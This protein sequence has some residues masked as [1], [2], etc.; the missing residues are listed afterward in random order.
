MTAYE[1]MLSESQERMLFVV[2]KGHEEDVN[3]IFDKWDLHAEVIG[4][5]EEGKDL[6]VNVEWKVVARIPAETLV[7][8][9]GAPVYQRE[10]RE[11]EYLTETRSFDMSGVSVPADLNSELRKLLR[12]PSIASKRWVF[13]QYDSMVRTNSVVTEAGDA[14]IVRIKGTQKA[15]A[16]KTDCNGRYVYLNPRVGA[17]IAVAESARNVV[18][19]GAVPVAITNCLNFGNPYDPEEYWQF[20]E[21]VLGIGDACRHFGTPV[22]GG[23]VSFYNESPESSVYPT[24]VI[25]MLGLLDDVK[26]AVSAR[27]DREGLEIVLVG[28]LSD[29]L[30]G[31]QYL[32]D[33]V[34]RPVGNCPEFDLGTE[35]AVQQTVLEAIKRG[36]VAAAHDVADGGLA[37]AL[38]EMLMGS[39]KLGVSV[40]L[41]AGPGRR[42][43]GVLFGEAQSRILIAVPKQN[44]KIIQSVAV[45]NG[46][47]ATAIGT[48]DSSGELVVNGGML[49]IGV[50]EARRI[51]EGAIPE[52]LAGEL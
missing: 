45:S 50:E 16:V 29:D 4:T 27:I 9:G 5:V 46:T 36:L 26:N 15:L 38:T 39:P 14:A 23:N 11:P 34:G 13:E 49:R 7:L 41:D 32:T 3:K 44:V 35:Q 6:V 33:R 1:I 8:G 31:S 52:M 42:M 48:V 51:Y 30:G 10:S 19:V 17:Q 20:K 43:D 47:V 12:H 18:C 24:P 40:K 28:P 37:V 25:G 2:K 22:T 21:A